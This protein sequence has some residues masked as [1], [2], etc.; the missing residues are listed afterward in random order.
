MPAKRLTRAQRAPFPP[1]QV[2]RMADAMIDGFAMH[3][4]LDPEDYP[5]DLHATMWTVFAAGLKALAVEG[6]VSSAG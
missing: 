3:Q 2:A 5:A 6:A 1:D 4:L